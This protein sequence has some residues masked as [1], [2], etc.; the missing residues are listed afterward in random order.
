MCWMQNVL[1]AGVAWFGIVSYVCAFEQFKGRKTD[2]IEYN[3][4]KV[5]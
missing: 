1:V 3:L 2:K 4:V 5:Q